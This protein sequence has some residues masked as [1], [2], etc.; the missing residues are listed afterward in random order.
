MTNHFDFVHKLKERG[1]RLTPQREMILEAVS[2]IGD[3]MTAEEI[4][5]KVQERTSAINITTIYRTLDLLVDEGLACR[6]DLGKGEYTYSTDLHG[7]H[8]HLI[9]RKCGTVIATSA[10]ILVPLEKLLVEQH[11]FQ[12]DIQHIS[13]FGICNHPNCQ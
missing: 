8:I 10:D 12:P 7:P 4:Y 9:C 6:T 3:H 13:L 11:G 2:L 5:S 1:Y